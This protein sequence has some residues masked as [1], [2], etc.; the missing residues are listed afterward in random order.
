MFVSASIPP[1]S[2]VTVWLGIVRHVGIVTDA[3]CRG[4]QTAISSSFKKRLVIEETLSQFAA[5]RPI[6]VQK[7]DGRLPPSEI[8]ARAREQLGHPW[9][10][11][12]NCEHV[13]F[14]AQGLRPRSPQL[15]GFAAIF[16]TAVAVAFARN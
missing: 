8:V 9:R 10:L 5:G 11:F 6:Q 1:G 2:L 16:A 3:W 7:P 13:A 4:E 15:E 12:D 14:R